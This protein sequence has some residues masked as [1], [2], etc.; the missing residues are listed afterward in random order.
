MAS[1]PELVA[2]TLRWCQSCRERKNEYDENCHSF[3]CPGGVDLNGSL[4]GRETHLFLRCTL[5]HRGG[6]LQSDPQEKKEASKDR[7][8]W[9]RDT[10]ICVWTAPLLDPNTTMVEIAMSQS[11]VTVDWRRVWRAAGGQVVSCQEECTHLVLDYPVPESRAGVEW[12]DM[13]RKF[14][15]DGRVVGTFSRVP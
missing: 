12:G 2:L 5:D 3:G 8:T 13:R 10:R 11:T 15:C 14:L 4:N 1:Y 7:G 9:G 6:L